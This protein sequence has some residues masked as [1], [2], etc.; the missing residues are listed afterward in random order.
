MINIV[1]PTILPSLV[2]PSIYCHTSPNMVVVHYY[3]LLSSVSDDDSEVLFL[4]MELD[5]SWDV[6]F[7][8]EWVDQ[9]SVVVGL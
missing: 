8:E 4:C 9:S 3:Y 1:A 5:Y 6:V 2:V 7:L